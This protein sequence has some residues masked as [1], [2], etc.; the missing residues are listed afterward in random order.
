MRLVNK[1]TSAPAQK[2]RKPLFST[3]ARL[4]ASCAAIISRPMAPISLGPK[5]L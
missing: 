5:R 3:I 1:P 4:P 2:W